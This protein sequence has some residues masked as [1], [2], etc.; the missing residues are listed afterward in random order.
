MIN[1]E[2]LLKIPVLILANKQ[3][4]PNAMSTSELTDKLDLEKLSC[5]R[6]WYIQPT[7]ATQNQ[8]LREGFEW[9]AETLVT[10]KVDMLEPLTETIKDWKT[11]KDDILSM[12]HSIGLKSFSS[13]FIQN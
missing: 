11:M 3:D 2:E 1:E 7:V 6:K 9:L 4:L 12:F 13:H 5:D 8:G 10:K